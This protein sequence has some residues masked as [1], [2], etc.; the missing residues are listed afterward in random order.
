MTKD[1]WEELYA[2]AVKQ[3]QQ[4][5][6]YYWRHCDYEYDVLHDAEGEA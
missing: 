2:Q 5:Q 3:Q 4:Q 1:C 6:I